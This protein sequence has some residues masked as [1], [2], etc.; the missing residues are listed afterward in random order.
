[1][2]LPPTGSE[3]ASHWIS[4]TRLDYAARSS[5]RNASCTSRM[6]PGITRRTLPLPSQQEA[7]ARHTGSAKPAQHALSMP[8]C[9]ALLFTR[10]LPCLTCPTLS[11]PSQQAVRAYH[12]NRSA[13][14]CIPQ[15]PSQTLLLARQAAL[16]LSHCPLNR[17]RDRI[18]LVELPPEH[19]DIGSLSSSQVR[20]RLQ[21]GQPI[22]GLVPEPVE[23][24]IRQHGL[25]AD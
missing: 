10:M 9:K 5:S 21:A 14:L 25:Y 17:Q 12:T 16:P 15:G 13:A 24:Y 8:C 11:P 3:S 18:T 1:M 4:Q 6:L 2:L 7:R 22:A 23:Q 20:A 19:S